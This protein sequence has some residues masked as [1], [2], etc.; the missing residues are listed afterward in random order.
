MN[1]EHLSIIFMGTPKFCLPTLK[2]LF[3]ADNIEIRAVVTQPDKKVG[4]KQLLTPTPVKE[5]ALK[6]KLPCFQPINKTELTELSSEFKKVDF[7]VILSY[8]MILS[9][10]VLAAPKVAPVNIHTSLLPKYRGASPI[11][12]ALLNGDRQTGISFMHIDQKLDHGPI[13]H[14]EKIEIKEKDDFLSLCHKL[15]KLS[16]EKTPEVLEKVYRGRYTKHPQKHSKASHCGKIEK[17]DGEIDWSK[18]AEE[19][20]NKWR[21]YKLWPQVYT[22]IDYKKLKIHQ[23]EKT[24]K[25]LAPGQIEII[26]KKLYIGTKS[27]ALKINN[28][29]LEGKQAMETADFL[30]GYQSF[31]PESLN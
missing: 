15:S 12:Q 11:H 5:F 7:L 10:E 8:G 4:R 1:Q 23:L 29:Q 26:N 22:E 25:K 21:A 16:G 18:G 2:T 3:K 24:D 17:E 30:N 13:Y 28:L 19:I 20:Y 6:N 27:N 9:N 31:L 14:Q